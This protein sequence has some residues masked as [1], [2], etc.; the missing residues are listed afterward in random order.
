ME[1]ERGPGV[2]DDHHHYYQEGG[3]TDQVDTTMMMMIIIIEVVR[4]IEEEI[5]DSDIIAMC[6]KM[7]RI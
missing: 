4:E 1:I 2:L 5:R 7:I 3:L 6:T